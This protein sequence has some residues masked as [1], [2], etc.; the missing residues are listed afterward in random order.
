ML[1]SLLAINIDLYTHK[2]AGLQL[3]AKRAV[4]SSGLQQHIPIT[5]PGSS[6][7]KGDW[8]RELECLNWNP[9]E[10]LLLVLKKVREKRDRLPY[11][12]PRGQLSAIMNPPSTADEIGK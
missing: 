8:K 1:L 2:V 10:C 11:W 6:V 5:D 9:S 7:N 3:S 12:L 4:V